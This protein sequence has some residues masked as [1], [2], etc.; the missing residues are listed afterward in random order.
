MGGLGDLGGSV[1]AD[2]GVKGSHLVVVVV[3][4]VAIVVM[5]AVDG[6]EMVVVMMH[7]C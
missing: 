4:L 6:V 1:I 5:V 2:V 3:T 7:I